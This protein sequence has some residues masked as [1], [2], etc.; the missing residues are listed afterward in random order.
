MVVIDIVERFVG[1][2]TLDELAYV[3][4]LAVDVLENEDGDIEQFQLENR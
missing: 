4:I 1:L 2:A 3:Y